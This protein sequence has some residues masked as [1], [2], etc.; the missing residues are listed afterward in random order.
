M[1]TH[2]ATKAKYLILVTAVLLLTAC[3]RSHPSQF[4]ILTAHH[5]H[6]NKVNADSKHYTLGVGPIKLPDYL[7]R[8]Q[9]VFKKQP[10]QIIPSEYHR[11]GE[12]LDTNMKSVII[13]N[14]A[15]ALTNWRIVSYPWKRSEHVKLQLKI[16][17]IDFDTNLQGDSTLILNW[18]IYDTKTGRV[19]INQ[20]HRYSTHVKD[21]KNY[22]K[23]ALAMSHNLAKASHAIGLNLQHLDRNKLRHT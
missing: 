13:S 15:E 4:Y 9:I 5:A 2:I 3:G 1:L 8:P 21:I 19:I 7:N 10:N 18:S 23:V 11:W 14:L 16:N 6:S 20:Q 17:I 22:N 12:P